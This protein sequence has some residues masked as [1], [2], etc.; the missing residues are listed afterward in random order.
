MRIAVC[1]DEKIIREELLRLCRCFR[2]GQS[3][4]IELVSFSS[5][6]EL[7][8]YREPV[9]ILFLD[10]QMRGMN[11]LE[12][13]LK[14]R[15]RNDSMS[16]IFLTGYRSFMQEGY[17]VKAFRYLLKPI[18]EKDVMAALGE[19]VQD[20]QKNDKA[21]TGKDGNLYFVKLSE[22]IYIEC[23]NRCT[24]VRT[25]KNC[26][27]SSSTMCEWES[28]LSS[29]NFFRVHKGYIVNL[30]FV[31]TVSNVILM[32]NGEKVALSLRNRSKFMKA[33]REFRRWNAG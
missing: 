16:I 12:T 25:V 32:E 31:D 3:A 9:D 19:A 24:L 18:K 10:V 33:C 4:A 21:V 15:E 6:E 22:I 30:R 13:A 28:V 26:F 8:R 2:E 1:D 29:G 20:L 14:I 7:L 23:G 5:G 11:G 27:E 17:R